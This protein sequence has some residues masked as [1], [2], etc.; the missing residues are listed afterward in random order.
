MRRVLPF[1]VAVLLAAPAC[2]DLLD[3]AA[4][5]VGGTKIPIEDV[6]EQLDRHV[7]SRA[8]EQLAA[9]GD[10]GA[11]QREFEQGRLTDLIRRVVLTRA[12]AE[13]DI[14]VTD[15]DVDQKIEEILAAQFDGQQNQL[16]EALTEQGLTEP[17]FREIMRD[18]IL[19][20]TLRAEVTADVEP[21]EEDVR[22]F[23]EENREEFRTTRSQ[24]ILVQDRA[25]ADQLA[26]RLQAA[27][28]AEAG[29]LF[30][31]LAREHSLDRR[32][33]DQG[34][35]LGYAP[36]GAFPEPYEAAVAELDPGEVSD[37]V[38][39]EA[40][41]HVARLVGRR[42]EPLARVRDDI[43]MQV[44]GPAQDEAWKKYLRGL[45]EDADIEV[46][47]RYGI[48]DEELL[49]VVDP[50]AEDIPA[51]EAPEPG[52]SP[53]APALPIPPPPG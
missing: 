7:D 32:S 17:Q 42:I 41:W 5:V 43:E 18:Q 22:A 4:A 8:Y 33:R 49:K 6:Q 1:V 24:H 28:E 37:P 9:Q 19:H 47:P 39:T 31:S 48:F 21:S 12:A 38:R 34:G 3:P 16:E 30:A 51:G 29:D 11:I 2:G 27:S 26:A 53:S 13:Y 14:E 44:T 46:N 35:D 10:A 52:A 40:G 15:S 50:D 45:F 25:L 20:E 36:R 23:Y